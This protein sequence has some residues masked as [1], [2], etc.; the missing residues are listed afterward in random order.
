MPNIA[1]MSVVSCDPH[2]E[3]CPD[4]V[5]G[6]GVVRA[7]G[8]GGELQLGEADPLDGG[9]GRVLVPE[10]G[11]GPHQVAQVEA[12][13]EHHHHPHHA[14]RPALTVHEV[15]DPVDGGLLPHTVK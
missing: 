13:A 12:G 10:H 2:V 9:G 8:H 14:V 4:G 3:D 6:R 1:N 11:G 7:H 15:A 5:C